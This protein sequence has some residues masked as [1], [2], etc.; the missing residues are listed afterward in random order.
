MT[1]CSICKRDFIPT[2][3][4]RAKKYCSKPCYWYSMASN[5]RCKKFRNYKKE[6]QHVISRGDS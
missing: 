6:N 3:G 1:I 2:K 5:K 4:S